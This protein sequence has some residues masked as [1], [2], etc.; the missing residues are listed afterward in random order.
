MPPQKKSASTIYDKI[1][2]KVWGTIFYTIYGNFFQPPKSSRSRELENFQNL[3]NSII[4]TDQS[5]SGCSFCPSGSSFTYKNSFTSE[6][7]KILGSSVNEVPNSFW[8]LDVK[9]SLRICN[10]CNFVILC[11]HLGL[12]TLKDKS[13]IFVKTPSFK[14]MYYLN[15]FVTEVYGSGKALG[16]REILGMSIIEYATRIQTSLGIWETMNIEVVNIKRNKIDFFSLPDETLQLLTNREIATTLNYLGEPQIL[17]L[18]L[19][20]NYSLLAEL[21]YRFLKESLSK[22]PN[23]K[24]IAKWLTLGK[25]KQN[26]TSTANRINKLY[27]LINEKINK[28]G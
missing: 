21:G 27:A 25:N 24:F 7:T 28:R 11:H 26:L 6:H 16:A 13:Q 15:K 5:A 4:S 3:I 9:N 8:N 2:E 23:N 17:G 12:I 22:K 19:N 18:V 14:S 20:R 10:L 1:I